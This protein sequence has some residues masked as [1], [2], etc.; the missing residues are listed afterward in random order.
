VKINNSIGP[1]FTSH[2]G[3]RQGDPLSPTLFNFVADCL[4]R[5]VRKA[6]R[7]DLIC[8]LADN[9]VDKGVAILQY[10]DDT[11]VYLKDD[12]S[13]ARN[14]KLLLYL[15]EM[16]S[17]LKI[18]FDK[19]EVILING[20]D[21]KNIIYADL[22]NCQNGSFPIKYLGVPVNPYKL[23]VA[24]WTPLIEKN[25]KKLATWKGSS[26]SIAGRTILINSS[27]SS[28]FIYH[29]SMYLL[30]KIVIKALDK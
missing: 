8:G 6:L 12:L 21:E 20:D 24:D 16:T 25:E 3:V 14:M 2:K 9:L 11:I 17:G 10:A 18:N 29:M 30:P 27:L 4:A 13:V 22:F 15:Y 19:S 28:S 5:M 7:N 1:Y 23:H 26:L